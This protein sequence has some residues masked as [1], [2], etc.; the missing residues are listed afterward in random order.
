MRM[1]GFFLATTASGGRST[2]P[3]RTVCPGRYASK[4]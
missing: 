1:F 3:D 2:P 4:K